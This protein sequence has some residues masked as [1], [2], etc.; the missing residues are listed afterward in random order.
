M[1]EKEMEEK[2]KELIEELKKPYDGYDDDNGN[3]SMGYDLAMEIVIDRLTEI[4][5]DKD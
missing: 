2:I 4:I 1:E 5:E 3:C